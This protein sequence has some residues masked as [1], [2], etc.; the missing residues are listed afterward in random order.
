MITFEKF[1]EALNWVEAGGRKKNVPPGD[2]GKATGPLQIHREY[3]KDAVDW[4]A[5]NGIILKKD[6][7]YYAQCNDWEYSKFIVYGYLKRYAS[8]AL[9]EGDWEKLA[10]I[11]N[12][13]PNGMKKKSTIPYWEKVADALKKI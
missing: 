4:Y 10:R 3:W 5:G 12:G 2:N 9:R 6:H 13:G 8:A 11:H 7:K 1:L